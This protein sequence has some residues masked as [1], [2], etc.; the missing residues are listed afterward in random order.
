MLV[1]TRSP[2][3]PLDDPA[4]ARLAE[5]VRAAATDRFDRSPHGTRLWRSRSA[6]AQTSRW[7]SRS[8]KPRWP[9]YDASYLVPAR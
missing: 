9:I 1:T 3:V 2:E 7:I 5:I 4:L 6:W 8:S